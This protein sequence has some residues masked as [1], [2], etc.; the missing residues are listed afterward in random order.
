MSN[1][2]NDP[3]TPPAVP[4]RKPRTLADIEWKDTPPPAEP[5]PPAPLPPAEIDPYTG[6]VRPRPLR[7][8]WDIQWKR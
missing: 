7:T 6:K 5:V 4:T 3:Q 2:Q 1:D 8:P